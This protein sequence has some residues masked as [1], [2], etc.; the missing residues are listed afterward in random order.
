MQY[1]VDV[2]YPE[3][4]KTTVTADE[5][6]DAYA[7]LKEADSP[8]VVWNDGGD[9]VLIV[10]VGDDHAVISLKSEETWYYLTVSGDEEE[11][12]VDMGGTDSYVPRKALAPRELGLTVLQR[13]GDLPGLR[14]DYSWD[15]Q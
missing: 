2:R 9:D 7:G 13:A 5:L 4:R 6:P 1:L 10:V 8:S 15:E 14:T 11:V 3:H 12:E